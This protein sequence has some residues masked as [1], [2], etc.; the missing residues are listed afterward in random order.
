MRLNAPMSGS[1]IGR[2]STG[3]LAADTSLSLALGLP[4]RNRVLLDEL[5]SQL[6][7]PGSTNFHKFLTAQQFAAQFGPSEQDYQAV[8]EFAVTNGLTMA[9]TH[10]DHIVLNLEGSVSNIE[11]AFGIRLHTYRHPTEGR[12]FFAPDTQPSAPPSLVLSEV[13]GL[14]DFRRP[15]PL[16]RAAR[17]LQAKPLSGS[18]PGGYYAGKDFRNAYAPGSSLTGAGQ[19]VGLLEFSDYFKVD[20]TNYQYSIGLTNYVPLKNVVVHLPAPTTANNGEVAL[21]IEVAIAMA[22]GLSQV[23]VYESKSVN[24]SSLLSRMADDNLAKQLSSSWSWSGGPSA[25]IDGIFQQ[26]A[27]QGQSFFQASGDSDAYTGGNALDN[28]ALADAPVDSPYITV[29]GGVTLAMNGSGSG[30]SSER[31]WNYSSFGGSEANVGSSGGISAYYPI[32]SWQ[33]NISMASNQGSTTRRCIPDVAMTGDGVYVAY[34]NGSS[35]GFAGTSCA[36]PLWAGFTALINQQS[37]ASSGKT[38]GFLN[39]ALYAIAT[40]PNYA[41]CFHDTSIGN[42]TGTNTPGFFNAT[43]GYD[44]CTGLGTPSGTNL[45]NALAPDLLFLSQPANQNATNGNNVTFN[46]GVGGQPPLVYRWLFNGIALT[47]GGNVSGVSGSALTLTP[48]LYGNAG[49]YDV[50]VTNAYGSI[51]SSIATLN[52]T[53]PPTINPQPADQTALAG[54][55][56][57][58][59]A[60]AAGASPLAYQWLKDGNRLNDDSGTSGATTP[61]VTLMGVTGTSA[62][63]YCLVVTNGYGAV[64]SSVASLNIV[65]PP[66]ITTLITNQIIECGDGA[67]F[68]TAA[69]GTPPLRRQWSIDGTP[70]VGATNTTL[71]LSNMHLPGRGIS[72]VVTNLYGRASNSAALTIIDTTPPVITL[73]GSKTIYGELGGAFSDPGAVAIDVCAGSIPVT[74]TGA[75]NTSAIG[76]NTLVYSANDGNGNTAAS[77]TRAIIVQDTTPPVVIWSFTNRVIAANADCTAEMPDVTGTNSIF[78]TDLSGSLDYHQFPTNGASLSLG[79]NTVVITVLDG[80]SNAVFSTNLI[81]VADESA[82][83]IMTQPQSRTNLVGT[84]TSFEILAAA[85]TP[86]AYQWRFNDVALTDQTNATLNFANVNAAASG[87]YT[88]VATG[89]GGSSTSA[90]A[91]LSVMLRTPTL[92]IASFENPSGYHDSVSFTAR[93]APTNATGSIQFLTNGVA[94]DLESL[95]EGQATSPSL[96]SLPRGTNVI[97]ASYSGDASD[98]SATHFLLQIVTNHPPIA[99]SVFYTRAAGSPFTFAVADLAT[100]WSDADGDT[101]LL[102]NVGVSTNHVTL[103]S[104]NNGTLVYSATNDVADQFVC[105]IDDGRGGTNFQIV[106]I[107]VAPLS[108]NSVPVFIGVA[109]H[110]DGSVTM[111]LGGAPGYT[112]LLE[113][114]TNLLSAG[115]WQAVATNAPGTNGV[116]QF[117]DSEATHYPQRYFRLQLS[118]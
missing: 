115:D 9:A 17:P 48:A 8:I 102:A 78:A 77:I 100:Q 84:S 51:T 90:V 3:R 67:T 68:V 55:N 72:V 36:A 81:I 33:T 6:Y 79:T 63:G 11:R 45:I 95:A 80:S 117:I 19:S 2:A 46:V 116:W 37:L 20:I 34:N 4:L 87:N 59:S 41:A 13:E 44:L 83:V 91:A 62:G 65:F 118:P 61:T 101:L 15:R 99:A 86:V 50:I 70:V 42:N 18:A 21:D 111:N 40:G 60:I 7:E 52:V 64:T 114:T 5:L 104:N 69:S 94:W 32:P 47:N 43:A 74:T 97:T 88:A 28:A 14:S 98:L 22:P 107:A 38:V 53:F 23:I 57:I 31:V 82:P 10:N 73:N 58:F 71:T 49:N 54:S 112:Y 92:T 30:W 56:V 103:A 105:T 35:S 96:A 113:A 89:S 85:C 16:M 12:D 110:A 109:A 76:T 39:P 26:M 75:V 24:P 27:A 106:N 93:V 29:V 108:T 1:G 25:T 66:L